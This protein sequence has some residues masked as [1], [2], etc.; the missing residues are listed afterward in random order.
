MPLPIFSE[1]MDC[2]SAPWWT[3]WYTGYGGQWTIWRC[4]CGQ[5]AKRPVAAR[6]QVEEE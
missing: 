5:V 6:V 1:P 3:Y 4:W 2:C